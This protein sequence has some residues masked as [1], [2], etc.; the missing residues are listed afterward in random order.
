[1]LI[2]IYQDLT[3]SMQHSANAYDAVFCWP[4]LAL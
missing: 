1:V 3:S 4:L 2:A